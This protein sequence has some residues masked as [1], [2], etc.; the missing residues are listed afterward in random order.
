MAIDIENQVKYFQNTSDLL[1]IP[2]LKTVNS[3]NNWKIATTILIVLLSL[4]SIS[5]S[6]KNRNLKLKMKNKEKSSNLY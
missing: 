6:I 4:Y 5:L 1:E 2:E 3:S